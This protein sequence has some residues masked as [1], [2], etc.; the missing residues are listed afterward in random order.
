MANL[1]P[2]LVNIL[3]L[4]A[5]VT[6]VITFG[7]LIAVDNAPDRTIGNSEAINSYYVNVNNTMLQASN[8]SI[9]S[10]NATTTGGTTTTVCLLVLNAIG[11]I[12]KTMIQAPMLMYQLTVGLI[13][14]NIGGTAFYMIIGVLGAIITFTIIFAVW[15]FLRVGES[16]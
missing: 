16:G 1:R 5:I 4:M 7:I 14:Q 13:V 2:L 11:G 15:K 9:A 10:Y 3:M 6:G 8:D 12:W